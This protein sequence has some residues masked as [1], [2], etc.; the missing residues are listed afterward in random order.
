MAEKFN[1]TFMTSQNE[2]AK[3]LC[4]WLINIIEFNRIF[5]EV[6]PLQIQCEEA[7]QEVEIKQQ[8]LAIIN[9]KVRGLNEKVAVLRKSLEEA[10]AKKEKVEA[11]ANMCLAK[12]SSAETLVNGLSGENE[13]WG[14]NVRKLQNNT[15]SIIG[16]VLLASSFVSYIGAFTASFRLNLW[17]NT[18]LPDIHNRKIPITADVTP[19]EI[20]TSDS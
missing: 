10:E 16:D 13:R 7:T 18:W 5:K 14:Q 2:A 15:L 19:L 12:L 8:Q 1:P 9:E 20:L 6:K 4:S 3:Y 11:E 17:S